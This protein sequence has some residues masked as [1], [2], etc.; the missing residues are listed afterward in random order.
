MKKNA[1]GPA[2]RQVFIHCYFKS[3][4]FIRFPLKKNDTLK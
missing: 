4:Q 3:K 2:T 1:E